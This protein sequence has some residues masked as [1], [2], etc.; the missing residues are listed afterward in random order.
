VD[1]VVAWVVLWEILVAQL[2]VLWKDQAD[3][4]DQVDQEDQED[5]VDQVGQ[6]DQAD[7]EDQAAAVIL[8]DTKEINKIILFRKL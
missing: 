1:Q 2:A 3:Q 4:A 8:E 5:Q 7:R 6:V